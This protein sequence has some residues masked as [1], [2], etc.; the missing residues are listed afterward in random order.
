MSQ[1]V[2][3]EARLMGLQQCLADTN[4]W[5]VA[6]KLDL[7][8][9]KTEFLVLCAPGKRHKILTT[10]FDVEGT[11][12]SNVACARNLEVLFDNSLNMMAHVKYVCQSAMIFLRLIRAVCNSIN[13]SAIEKLVHAF[14]TS[15]LD[16]C[17]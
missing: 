8:L 1:P 17:N 5:I 10:Q 9:K 16:Y 15:R 14:I 11:L 2:S 7:N 4:K 6:N 12:V 3:H 13:Q